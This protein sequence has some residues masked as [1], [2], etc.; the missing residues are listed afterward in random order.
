MIYLPI[1]RVRYDERSFPDRSIPDK[2][3]LNLVSIPRK[4]DMSQFSPAVAIFSLPDPVLLSL[5]PDCGS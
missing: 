2:H 5:N 1:G 3:A 4:Y